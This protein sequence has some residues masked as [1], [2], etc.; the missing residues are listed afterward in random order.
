MRPGC[1]PLAT[2]VALLA[3]GATLAA[4]GEDRTDD[5]TDDGTRPGA[6]PAAE[7]RVET[8]G[9]VWAAGGTI[10]L[11][12][13]STLDAGSPVRSFVV[14]EGGAY[15][16]PDTASDEQPWPELL[17]VTPDGSDRLGV[18]P[19]ADSLATS[20]DGR[21]LAFLDRSGERDGY[22]TPLAEAVVVDL[23]TGEEVL[24]SGA[25]MGD[26]ATDDLTDLYEDA[27]P[28]V[29]G[30]DDEHAWVHTVGDVRSV[31]LG[32][33]EVEV[34]EDDG[35]IT[36][37][38]WY[39]ALRTELVADSPDGEWSIRPGPDGERW[40]APQLVADDGRAVVTRLDGA[41]LGF[42]PL[43]PAPRD[44]TWTLDSWLDAS[45]AVG[46][47]RVSAS[48]D[49]AET[50]VLVTCTVPDGACRAVPGTEDGALVPVDRQDGVLVPEP[51]EVTP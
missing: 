24:R 33:G 2:A 51:V 42:G 32:S 5:G 11:G 22:D 40:S 44:V 4:C 45:T 35:G 41:D 37:Q 10:H 12:D 30:V 18:H 25:G 1:R 43:D 23:T 7:A 3:I 34:V 15:V 31:A 6:W 9:L 14:A 8:R 49:G 17:R 21:H 36:D 13:G 50:W 46:S 38:P 47:A 48:V 20:P 26:P 19:E 29:I 28:Y 39:D 27:T 16:V